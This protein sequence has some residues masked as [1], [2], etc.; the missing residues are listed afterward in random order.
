MSWVREMRKGLDRMWDGLVKDKLR[1]EG[2]L[3]DMSP[4]WWSILIWICVGVM[5]ICSPLK[6]QYI[7]IKPELPELVPYQIVPLDP[8]PDC[9]LE[10]GIKLIY[11]YQVESLP[12]PQ[13]TETIEIIYKRIAYEISNPDKETGMFQVDG[14]LYHL[15][16]IPYTAANDDKVLGHDW[17]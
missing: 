8:I 11:P 17:E 7:K 4:K 1:Q 12:E 5:L 16:R 9:R 6:G 13:Q 3:T 10:L 14:K 2:L 15:L